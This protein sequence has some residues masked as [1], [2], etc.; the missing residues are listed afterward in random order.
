MLPL[1]ENTT[2]R[3]VDDVRYTQDVR[4]LKL[5]IMYARHVERREEVWAFL[6]SRDIGTRHATFYEEW[7]TAAEGLGRKKKADEVYR[8]GIAR[9][10]APMER[11]RNRHQAFLQRIMA[12]PSG[13]VPDDD[14]PLVAPKQRS[15]LGQV[16]GGMSTPAV[17]PGSSRPRANNGSKMEIFSDEGARED[18][19]NTPW[20]EFGTRDGRRKENTIEAGPWKG[21]TL[22]QSAA[23]NRIAPRTPKIE[24]FKDTNAGNAVAVPATDVI[25]A[26]GPMSEA[27]LLRSDPLRH[28]DNVAAT[29][30]AP[31]PLP[32]LPTSVRKPAPK[33]RV[34]SNKHVMM[35]WECPTGGPETQLPN[36]KTERR[37][38]DWEATFK[39]GEEWSFEEVRARKLGLLGN[40]WKPLKEWERN[41]HAPGSSTPKPAKAA[42][43]PSPTLNTKLA[44]AEVMDLFNQT[45]HGGKVR[46]D[47]SSSDD[48]E[49]DEEAADMPQPLPTP[50][51]M[52]RQNIAMMTP[53]VGVPP[54]PT[55]APRLPPPSTPNIF[56]ATPAASARKLQVFSDENAE[57]DENAVPQSARKLNVFS[58]T[59]ARAPLGTRTPMSTSRAFTIHD[60]FENDPCATPAQATPVQ[61]NIFAGP[62]T[63]PAVEA[64]L[65]EPEPN[66]QEEQQYEQDLDE[67][68][69]YEERYGREAP[70]LRRHP[71]IMTPVAERTC[72]Y[73]TYTSTT[74]RSRRISTWSEDG[75]EVAS[76]GTGPGDAL[77]SVQEEDERSSRRS[78]FRD[79][80]DPEEA[81][82]A[83]LSGSDFDRSGS[84][85]TGAFGVPEGYTIA[86]K[87]EQTTIQEDTRHT[88]ASDDAFVTAQYGATQETKQFPT[89]AASPIARAVPLQAPEPPATVSTSEAEARPTSPAAEHASSTLSEPPTESTATLGELPNPCNPAD[90]A[91][92]ATLLQRVQPAVE[93]M[94]QIQRYITSS[95]R[96]GAMRR[97]AKLQARRSSSASSRLSLSA[98]D[99]YV[100]ELAGSRYEIHHKLGEGGYGA[101]FLA[102]DQALQ[103]KL[104]DMDSDDED[105][106]DE[107][108]ALLAVKV[109]RPAAVWEAVVLDRLRTRVNPELLSSIIRPRGLHAFADESYLLLDYCSQGTLLD[110]V[111]K[112]TVLGVAVDGLSVPEEIMALFFTVEL[113]KLV[114][115]LHAADFIHGDL[116]IDNCLVRLEPTSAS[117]WSTQYDRHGGGGWKHKGIRLIDFGRATDFTLFPAGNKQTFVSN[118][119]TDERD[120]V[121]MREGR[122][123]SYETDYFG[124]A[125]I[126]YC[127]L[128][129]KYIGTE[130]VKTDDGVRYKIDAPLKRVSD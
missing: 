93:S 60:D 111:N 50:L 68:N 83:P 21:E 112:A 119:K 105:E 95:N 92:T 72:E 13:E 127:L 7:A 71:D 115:G 29:S 6:E 130:A 49:E 106:A 80:E 51:P 9:R 77:A 47:D 101:V 73:T 69:Y 4:Y 16:V 11:L 64:I 116:K 117:G 44:S 54:T 2:R 113:L 31:A 48:D 34:T 24:V 108:A 89:A 129:G 109:E 10:A 74:G 26:S 36:G 96:L 107:N 18:P 61:R 110:V 42:R 91:V 15:V 85:D 62:A 28:Y 8:L 14:P 1:L 98:E 123:W 124:L 59:P 20:E 46:E 22:P 5:W 40:D 3:F 114:E 25:R 52:P 81:E 67:Y 103:A 30:S 17:T 121:E 63:A 75:E 37:M 84:V 82:A 99:A 126:C 86:R 58:E 57:N 87:L 55:P 128:F 78:P 94:S 90:D 70:D 12:P 23:R 19:E 53:G 102:V 120:C 118:W 104:D 39:G 43:V 45:L 32:A 88:S 79:V 122:P 66:S 33:K 41:W 56:A 27:E 35:P 100:L 38:F 65:E 97:T 76:A 125:S